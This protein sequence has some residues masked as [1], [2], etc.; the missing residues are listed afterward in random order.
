MVEKIYLEH[1]DGDNLFK[2]GGFENFR[3]VYLLKLPVRCHK[4]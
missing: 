4:Y 1:I 3:M 2:K